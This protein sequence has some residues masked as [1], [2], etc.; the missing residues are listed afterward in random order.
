MNITNNPTTTPQITRRPT[1]AE[2]PSGSDEIS[3]I[4][5]ESFTNSPYPHS[6]RSD[7]AEAMGFVTRLIA[8]M[9]GITAGAATLVGLSA[10]IGAA[11]A[12]S[13]ALPLVLV[14]GK[15]FLSS[16]TIGDGPHGST[17]G[18]AAGNAAIIGISEIAGGIGTAVGLANGSVLAGAATAALGPAALVGALFL[19]GS[20]SKH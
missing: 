13:A 12:T 10:G 3:N 4:P 8:P 6:H 14:L 2:K 7:A 16:L 9:A 11:V 20:L 18:A 17:A 19:A 1:A 15:N 5:G